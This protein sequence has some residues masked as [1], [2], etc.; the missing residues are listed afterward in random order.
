MSVTRDRLTLFNFSRLNFS[1]LNFSHLKFSYLLT[2]FFSYLYLMKLSRK[3]Q[4]L[5]APIRDN[6]LKMHQ[7]RLG[8]LPNSVDCHFIKDSSLTIRIERSRSPTE[9]FLLRQGRLQLA[10]DVGLAINQIIKDEIVR[11]LKD[12]FHLPIIECSFLAP[13]LIESFSLWTAVETEQLKRSS[14]LRPA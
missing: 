4:L 10:Q 9:Q 3:L 13:S 14:Q 6:I 5:E 8:Y 1:R 7:A 12:D 2:L 11:I